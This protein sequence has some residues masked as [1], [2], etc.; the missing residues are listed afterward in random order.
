MRWP[1]SDV[2][3]S[4]FLVMHYIWSSGKNG[5]ERERKISIGKGWRI[6]I[7]HFIESGKI[8]KIEERNIHLNVGI[9]DFSV[10]W[11]R[12]QIVNECGRNGYLRWFFL[13]TF[14]FFILS[15]CL[16]CAIVRNWAA[17]EYCKQINRLAN[18]IHDAARRH[19]ETMRLVYWIF[20]GSINFVV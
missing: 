5:K 2:R 18:R 1:D 12:F 16:I 10:G 19:V 17:F 7:E 4:L 6:R 11:F 8:G 20:N 15:H 9:F 13:C 14:L 3:C